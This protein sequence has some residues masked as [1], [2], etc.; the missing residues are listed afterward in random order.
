MYMGYTELKGMKSGKEIYKGN[1]LAD[2]ALL[3]IRDSCEGLRFDP[4][5]AGKYTGKSLKPDQIPYNMEKDIDRLCLENALK[6]FLRSGR[7]EDAFDVYFCYLEMF[8]GS[9]DKTRR[10]IELLSEYEANGSRL[11]MSHRDHY[12][13]SVYVFALGLAV[14]QTNFVY[15]EKYNKFYGLANGKGAA[16]H[17]LKYW[18]LASLFHDIGYPFELPFEQVASYFEVNGNDR[19]ERPYISYHKLEDFLK[20][21]S[22]TAEKLKKIY[23]GRGFADTNELFAYVLSRQLGDTYS[24]TVQQLRIWLTD[25]PAEPNKFGHFMDHAYF[26]ASVLFNKLFDEMNCE[27]DKEHIDAITA[28]LLHNSLYKFNIAHYKDSGNIPFKADLH[29]VA[30]MLMLCDELQCWDRV[31]YGRNSRTE[32]HPMSCEFD[33]KDNGIY[34][35]YKYDIKEIAKVNRYKDKYIELM[36]SGDSEELKKLELKAYSKMYAKSDGKTEFEDDIERIVDLSEIKLKVET[37]LVSNAHSGSRGTLSGSNFM[38]LHNFA[39]VLNGRWGCSEDWKKAKNEGNVENFI[40]DEERKKAFASD[41][42]KLS[43]EYKLSN[44]NQA[45]A[46]AGYMDVIGCFYSDSEVDFETVEGFSEEE[47]LRIGVLEHKRWLQEHYDM[48]WTYGE[49]EE[50]VRELVRQ[51]KDMIPDF[52]GTEVSDEKAEENYRRL[53]KAEQD[54]DTDPM[55]CMLALLKMYDGIRIYRLR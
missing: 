12:S 38:H 26:S 15:R 13:H 6:R 21:Q 36:T 14:Y 5:Q 25:K 49:P 47:I 40:R 4:E 24:F 9:Y 23:G 52:H 29:P 7:K 34:A 37:T 46:F 19:K 10:M 39:I 45:K 30:Y 54:K 41:F 44:I 31:A 11:L 43:L 17:Y 51:H 50:A 35:N 53:D 1:G 2:Q 33:F 8:V 3:F 27:M 32:L 22:S 18:G 42:D 55:D 20:I 48:G 28:I 16:C